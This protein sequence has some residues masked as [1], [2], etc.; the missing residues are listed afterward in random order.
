[1]YECRF[2]LKSKWSK[3]KIEL[4]QSAFDILK[5]RV[6]IMF[7]RELPIFGTELGEVYQ[8][9]STLHGTKKILGGDK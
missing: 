6:E 5:T 9:D 8:P 3:R 1:L 4:N 7:K 2:E